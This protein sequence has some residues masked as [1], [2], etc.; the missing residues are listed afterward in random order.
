MTILK[1]AASDVTTLR[2]LNAASVAD[3]TIKSSSYIPNQPG[4][5]GTMNTS[6]AGRGIYPGQSV[7]ANAAWCAYVNP[8]H[9]GLLYGPPPVE[10]PSVV[11][12]TLDY[13]GGSLGVNGNISASIGPTDPMTTVKFVLTNFEDGDQMNNITISD[14][15]DQAEYDFTNLLFLAVPE[16]GNQN[17]AVWNAY[18]FNQGDYVDGAVFTVTFPTPVAGFF[19]NI[20]NTIL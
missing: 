12:Y 13:D 11:T 18:E 9:R 17:T 5:L 3:P 4:L 14:I 10:P 6:L 16:F 8:R 1:G 20:Q 7:L 2:R 15:Y 19:V